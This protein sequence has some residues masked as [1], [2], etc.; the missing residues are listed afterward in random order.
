[1][2]FVGKP[3]NELEG[4][5][6]Q[7]TLTTGDTLYASATNTLS[8]LPI[9]TFP[10]TEVISDGALPVYGNNLKYIYY[11]DDFISGHTVSNQG[12]NVTLTGSGTANPAVASLIESG[13]PGIINVTTAAATNDRTTYS[14]FLNSGT[15]TCTYGTGGGPAIL[16]LLVKIPTLSD[17]TDTFSIKLGFGSDSSMPNRDALYFQYTHGS[18]SGNWQMIS[19]VASGTTTTTNSS[20]AADTNWNLMEIRINSDCTSVGFY[21]NGSQVANSPVTATLPAGAN[22]G[23]GPFVQILK[24]AGTNVRNIL[25]DYYEYSQIL[26][27]AR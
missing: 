17:A 24:S 12:W 4:G 14:I 9:N 2:A 25:L 5:T 1:M 19:R 3:A 26:V 27:T 20:T 23:V 22:S 15:Y 21:I 8:K 11:N 6:N 18:N 16:K 7:T 10:C 13:H